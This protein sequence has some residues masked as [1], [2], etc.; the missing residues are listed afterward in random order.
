MTF[1]V[2]DRVVYP[3]QGAGVVEEIVT[4]TI[5]GESQQYLKISF[6]RGGMDMLV[7]LSKGREVGLRHTVKHEEIAALQQAMK[8]ADLTLPTQWPPRYRAEQEILS[9][10]QALML[11]KLIGVLTQ[12]DLERGLAGTERQVLETAKTML[13]S[14]LAIVQEIDF[15]EALLQVEAAVAE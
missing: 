7:P 15:A 4:R 6:V 9:A 12:R 5:L 3:S 11:A 13:A 10:G 1:Q 14:E 2:G 8:D